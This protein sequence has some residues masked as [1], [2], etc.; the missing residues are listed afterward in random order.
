MG[1][2]Q[3]WSLIRMSD[4]WRYFKGRTEPSRPSEWQ[5]L[6][7]N[8]SEWAT[9]PSGFSSVLYSLLNE[10]TVLRDF[11]VDY[12]SLYLR[13]SFVVK[14]PASI[15]WLIL[16]MDYEDGVVAYLNGREIVRR[17]FSGPTNSPVPYTALAEVHPRGPTE[18]VDISF[19]RSVLVPGTNVLALQVHSA[20]QAFD[21]SISISPEL[22]ANFSRGP[23][24]QNASSNRI[25]IIWKTP[26]PT[27]GRVDFG[28]GNLSS[29][30]MDL[31]LSTNHVVV[32]TNL[33]PGTLYSYKASAWKD[34]VLASAPASTFRTLQLEGPI[35]F[36][37]IGDT[38]FGGV[39]QY[40]IADVL[41]ST[42]PDMVIQVGDVVY[43]AFS[44]DLADLRCFSV[45]REQM[46]N[47]TF[48]YAIGNHD[49]YDNQFDF[50]DA[51]HLPT[52]SVTGGEDFYSFDHGDAHFVILDSDL[53]TGHDYRPGS[54][55]YNWLEQDLRATKR[56]W[57]FLFFHHTIRTS[58]IHGADDYNRNGI[59]DSVELQASIG[60]LAEKYGVQIIFNGHDHGY[61][62]FN[63]INGVGTFVSG[64][65]GA[66]LYPLRQ[67]Q[68]ESAHYLSMYECLKVVVSKDELAVHAYDA[69]GYLFD[70]MYWRR[71]PPERRVY[72]AAFHSP[73]V[74]TQPANDLDGNVIG[75][76]FDF[77]G[78]GIGTVPGR[79]SNLGRVYVN[80]DR[81][82]LYVG[83]EQS[84]IQ[85]DQDIF[86]FLAVPGLKG[87]T[88]LTQIGNGIRDPDKEGAD[89]LDLLANLSFTNFTPFVAAI[90]GDE[91][92]DTQARAFA[93]P[94][95]TQGMGQG[96]FYLDTRISDVPSA[97]L[98]Q[99]NWR[100]QRG[101]ASPE[102]NAD[103]IEIVI[104]YASL[105]G[106]SPGDTMQIGAVTGLGGV[107]SQPNVQTQDLDSSYLGYSLTQGPEGK[108]VLEGLS[109]KLAD[110]PSI[111]INSI[112]WLKPDRFRLAWNS[113]PGRRYDV[114]FSPDLIQPFKRV[115]SPGLPITATLNRT[116][117]EF[118]LGGRTAYY[119]VIALE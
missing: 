80:N 105:G 45:Y 51:F 3:D 29:S 99:F 102:S 81:R 111:F 34:D 49:S 84:M 54:P 7:F 13:K 86:L 75:Q 17:G 52:N 36:G 71:T 44:S 62:K 59:L 70:S 88:N 39:P 100:V 116:V 15:K 30:A 24:L 64:G 12:Q 77:A 20:S 90:L 1:R 8:D 50:F 57:K 35:S 41:R 23:L 9:G 85:S 108:A 65:G 58:S 119:R 114:E 22:F 89:G 33:L 97:R 87:V 60:A 5:Q 31:A 82:N 32:L 40:L 96:I 21:Y 67:L 6:G 104:P 76:F 95:A 101:P 69:S 19:A 117:F 103:F 42:A 2:A 92:G 28:I 93:R 113:N 38:G 53:E 55:Q 68:P 115:V 74:E 18:E 37:V 106:L 47:T 46:F 109:V 11:G 27:F 63:L 48:F 79:F 91:W 94:G 73:P 14:D 66:V 107:N 98:Q 4:T 118:P 16:R 112:V 26:V 43:P 110:D 10:A 56:P 83:F 61:E 78:E 72:S 25:E